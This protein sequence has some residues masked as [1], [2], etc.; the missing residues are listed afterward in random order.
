[1][2]Q[3]EPETTGSFGMNLA[4]SHNV[5]Y[6]IFISVEISDTCTKMLCVQANWLR[7]SSDLRHRL[8]AV[9]RS[10][11]PSSRDCGAVAKTEAILA[12]APP[13]WARITEFDDA[14][15]I[16]RPVSQRLGISFESRQ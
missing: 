7:R 8:A 14:K 3:I 11:G 13:P 12:I 9:G 15:L 6:G 1:M 4:D 16:Q 10:M 5:Y 2:I